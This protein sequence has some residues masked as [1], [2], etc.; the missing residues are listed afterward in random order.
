MPSSPRDRA[1]GLSA[2][3]QAQHFEFPRRQA[4][5]L[6][7]DGAG[8]ARRVS[9]S[10]SASAG[11]APNWRNTRGRGVPLH[12][13]AVGV[14]ER[15]ARPADEHLDARRLV[16][17]VELAPDRQRLAQRRQRLRA[18]GRPQGARRRPLRRPSRAAMRNRAG[19]PSSS[20]RRLP[21]A[22]PAHRLTA[23]R[24]STAA[25]STSAR[26]R[27]PRAGSAITRSIAARAASRWPCARRS[28]ARPGCGARPCSLASR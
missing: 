11:A 13:R 22:P 6:L 16:R 24:I 15:T 1:V 19:R 17:R 27:G 10:T 20:T 23:R 3:N 26:R 2:G 8:R 5:G 25:A 12:P 18:A 28:S 14:A 4:A 21:A 9:A 7:A